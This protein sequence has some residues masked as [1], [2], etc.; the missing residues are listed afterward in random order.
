MTL[1]A[2]EGGLLGSCGI[3]GGGFISLLGWWCIYYFE[4]TWTPPGITAR[5]PLRL[6]FSPEYMAYSLVF[7]M[8]LCVIASLVPAR[9]AAF[10]NVV[11]A[12]GHV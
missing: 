4:P 9:K 5:I 12:L 6:Q 11:D 8:L 7:L 2:L 3:L 1:F 10:Q